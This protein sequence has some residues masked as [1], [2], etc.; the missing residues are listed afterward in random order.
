M[1]DWL[2]GRFSKD[3]GVD[4]GTANTVICVSG[5]GIALMEPSVVAVWRGTNRILMDG[6][7]IGSAA[8]AMIGRTP[9]SIAA[10]RPLREGVIADLEITEAMLAYF[11]R[12]VH[13]RTWGIKP[14]V[15][16]AVPTGITQVEKQAVTGSAERAGSRE[17]Y[18]IQ[19]P[20]AAAIG[21]GLDITEAAGSMVVDIGGGTTDIAVISLAGIVTANTTRVA[22]D[23]M[24]R[25]VIEHMKRTYNLLI[26]ETTAEELKIDLGSAWPMA[27]EKSA[28]VRGRDVITG[29]PRQASVSSEEIREALKEPV[30]RIVEAMK[31]TLSNAGPELASDL[32]Q[33]G[34]VMAGGGSLL[35]GI[36]RVIS[37]DT[38]LPVRVAEDP[39]KAVARGTG[40]V[41]EQLDLLKAVLESSRDIF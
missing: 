10:V 9:G 37:H 14:R 12:K 41:L 17:G 20:M 5:E 38:G 19:E 2:L 30:G 18:L 36:D 24:D 40:A 26:G 23:A 32:I 16:V 39:M 13:A 33:R 27:E 15:V 21:I 3:L 25:A 1:L 29:L 28:E 4:L 22:G 31:Q 6:Q 35:H 34:V 7:A 8:K 11:I